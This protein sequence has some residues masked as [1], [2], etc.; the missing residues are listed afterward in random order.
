[1][2]ERPAALVL[3]VSL[4]LPAC[5]G[6]EGA[7]DS[8]A[9]VGGAFRVIAMD[10]A[11]EGRVATPLSSVT[12]T[13]NDTVDLGSATGDTVW[14]RE[15]ESRR[16]V[17][18][19]IAAG[20]SADQV[21]LRP[22]LPLDAGYR[23]TVDV[24]GVSNPDGESAVFRARFFVRMQIR[25]DFERNQDS[26]LHTYYE[27]D[28]DDFARVRSVHWMG[29][30]DDHVAGTADDFLQDLSEYHYDSQQDRLYML[31]RALPGD[32]GVYHTADDVLR[33][34]RYYLYSERGVETVYHTYPGDDGALGTADDLDGEI[35]T[36]TYDADTDEQ[37]GICR[38][39]AGPD[40][41][42]FTG[43]DS[44][45]WC[46]RDLE[47]GGERRQLVSEAPGGD[48][49]WLTD[50]DVLGPTYVRALLD[51]DGAVVRRETHALAG[52]GTAT[53]SAAT[54]Q[55]Y[56][57]IDRDANHLAVEWR[58]YLG[59]GTGVERAVYTY[60]GG[61]F[62]QSETVYEAG[63]DGAHATG[64]DFLFTRMSWMW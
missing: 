35:T 32:D 53:P 51:A 18:A 9:L 19:T 10:P 59:D 44:V 11:P 39:D 15:R 13:F 62:V 33:V 49:E 58:S 31:N 47:L 60:D 8:R 14:I 21:V 7:G 63:G 2:I 46:H 6:E 26:G 52:D 1:M 48:G 41:R 22:V 16:R 29:A 24:D 57:E 56:T 25:E 17:A 43:D 23:Y 28:W 5:A 12:L 55:E 20:P 37:L 61:G 36:R 50:D 30:G 3:L 34:E 54:L 38:I 64:D 27:S 42:V 40:A 45:S 4:C